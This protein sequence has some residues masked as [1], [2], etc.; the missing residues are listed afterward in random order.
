MY[1]RGVL[2]SMWYLINQIKGYTY[3]NKNIKILNK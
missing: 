2:Y 1:K 3:N